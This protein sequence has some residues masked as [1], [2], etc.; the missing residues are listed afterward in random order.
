MTSKDDDIKRKVRE[1]ITYVNSK[2]GKSAQSIFNESG[3]MDRKLTKLLSELK[4]L[5]GDNGHS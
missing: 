2:E 4:E 5:K 1:V 3:V